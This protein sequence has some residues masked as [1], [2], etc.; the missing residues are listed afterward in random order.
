MIF[1][2]VVAQAKYLVNKL[3]Q[4]KGNAFDLFPVHPFYHP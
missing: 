2:L 4:K 3:A 1:E